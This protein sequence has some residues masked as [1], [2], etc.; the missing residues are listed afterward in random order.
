MTAAAGALAEPPVA[1]SALRQLAIRSFRNLRRAELELPAAGIALVGENGQGKTNFL[2]AIYYLRLL[3]SMRGAQDAELVAFGEGG[4]HLAAKIDGARARE[5]TAGFDRVARRK[6]I[7]LDGREPERMVDALGAFPAVIFSPR[8]AVLV[9]GAP[10]ERRRFLD[11]ML[12]LSSRPYLLALQRYRGALARRNAGMREMQLGHAAREA[13]AAVWEPALAAHGAVLF[14]AR[15]EWAQAHAARYASRCE[16]IGEVGTAAL[17][18]VSSLD[19][20]R[21]SAEEALLAALERKRPLDVKRG[22]THAGPHRD[23]LELTLDARDL[24]TYGSAGQQRTA[25]IALRL[26]EADTL[27]D[28]ARA[29]PLVLLDDPFAELDSRRAGRILELLSAEE[30]GQ[31]IVAVPRD[32]DIPEAFTRLERWRVSAGELARA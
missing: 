25:A 7:T 18:Y 16:A 17:R 28:A 26:L 20:T 8:D 15:Q 13:C 11:V 4:F 14:T 23:D 9:S 29:E 32:A 2:E 10:V 6:K 19:V 3:R 21:A 12:A 30:R 24:R 5:V 1:H 27:R 22:V 31:T